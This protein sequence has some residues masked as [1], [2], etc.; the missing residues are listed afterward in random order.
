MKKTAAFLSKSAYAIA[1]VFLALLVYASARYTFSYDLSNLRIDPSVYEVKDSLIKNILYFVVIIVIL[2]LTKQLLF[3]K[4]SD[5]KVREKRSFLFAVTVSLAVFIYLVYWVSQT[6]MAP[7][8]DQK[9]VINYAMAFN[10]GDYSGMED[11]Y[12]RS[13]PHQ[14]GQIFFD[15]P[16]LKVFKNYIVFQYLNAVFVGLCIFLSSRIVKEM[17]LGASAGVYA[18]CLTTVFIPNYYYVSHI[19]GDLF[20]LFA[21]FMI[22]Y[23]LLKYKNTAKIR[24]LVFTVIL[25]SVM[26]PIRNNNII[27]LLTLA[28]FFVIDFLNRKE[29][30]YLLM[31][32][33]VIALPLALTKGIKLYYNFISPYEVS[34]GA[35]QIEWVIMATHGDPDEGTGVGYF[36]GTAGESWI[37]H[38]FDDVITKRFDRAELIEIIKNDIHHGRRTYRFYRYKIDEQ[39]TDPTFASVIMTNAAADAGTKLSDRVYDTS[40]LSFHYG[41]F[42]YILFAIY[43]LAL[44]ALVDRFLKDT[45][46]DFLVIYVFFVGVFLFSLIWEASGR[47]TMPAVY[48]LIVPAAWGVECLE[49]AIKTLMTGIKTRRAVNL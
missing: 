42:N 32:V 34:A 12:L 5:E 17:K 28:I 44:I 47:Y 43:L 19:Y 24:F 16:V 33:L 11:I 49:K 20:S 30:K 48:F 23:M 22:L 21:S 27:F 6:K 15:E 3:I 1:F 38:D 37:A 26:Y 41:M 39:W 14:F 4:A 35:P 2:Y 40:F 25:A 18:V 10:D 36:D 9:R 13:L 46:Y 29:K 45:E 7:Y 31:A 8:A